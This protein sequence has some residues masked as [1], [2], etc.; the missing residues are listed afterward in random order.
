M[1]NIT[2]KE[3]KFNELEGKIYKFVCKLGCEILKIILELQDRQICETRDKKRY[4]YAKR[5]KTI[6]KTVMGEVEY[7]HTIYYDRQKPDNEK[8]KTEKKTVSLLKEMLS[9]KKCGMM[10]MNVVAIIKSAI[11]S[12]SY[13]KT[14]ELVM[15]T[16]N[17]TISAMGV[18]E[19]IQNYAE[20]LANIENE[21]IEL[22]EKE[23]LD[24]GKKDIKV[25]YTEADGVYY[26]LQGK[27]RKKLITEYN[28]K[29]PDKELNKF[30]K[31]IKVGIMY[32]GIKT[33]GG[34]GRKELVEKEVFAGIMDNKRLGQLMKVFSCIKYNNIDIVL[35]NSDGLGWTNKKIFPKA[36]RQLDEYHILEKIRSKVCVDE[37]V[38][39]LRKMY[40]EEKFEEM[41]VYIENLKSEY[42]YEETECKKLDQLKQYLSNNY[43]C[44]GRIYKNKE[45][46]NKL[47][48]DKIEH[49][50]C[51][52]S[53]NFSTI[54]NRFKHRRMSFS[55]KGANNLAIVLSTEKSE[56]K[57]TMYDSINKS[58]LPAQILESI[59]E[60]IEKIE[61]NIKTCKTK[62][63]KQK[64]ITKL[65]GGNILNMGY[66]EREIESKLRGLLLGI[67]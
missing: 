27:D 51:Q 60:Y 31:E 39:K 64:E 58:K 52:E 24:H 65:P 5:A 20:E 29:H 8:V 23:I 47:G 40:Y 6:I 36:I 43:D 22:N 9:I 57:D 55:E 35:Q 1:N 67:N 21:L 30:K 16:T 17:L 4:R 13:R 33:I 50:G 19:V 41:L 7:T 3:I 12:L 66:F 37:D 49:M 38:F 15:N 62:I 14:A 28:K 48:V 59:D 32:E 26:T 53:N 54:T 10:S 34:Q 44:L 63:K 18:W 25:L 42:S 11:S 45:L 46:L 61:K 2:E 56:R